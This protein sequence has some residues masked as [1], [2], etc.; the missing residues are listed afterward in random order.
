MRQRKKM[1]PRLA[2]L[3]I[4]LAICFPALSKADDL[5]PGTRFRGETQ[6]HVIEIPVK[7]ID[8]KTGRAVRDLEADDF[9]ILED[10]RRQEISN[11][12]E[13]DISDPGS[14]SPDEIRHLIYFFDLYLMK[15]GDRD[16][17]V[18]EIRKHYERG[19]RPSEIVSIASFDGEM[20]NHLDSSRDSEAI[21]RA[22]DEVEKL[23][24]RG[25]SQR[26]V[27]TQAL[28]TE[29]VSGE[30]K[31]DYYDRRHRSREFMM[32]LERRV[33]KTG[34]AI[35]TVLRRFSN[36]RGRKILIVFSP[37]QP[38]TDW[39]P[40]YAPVDYLNGEVAYP[41]RGLWSEVA[42]EAADLGYSMYVI[43]SRGLDSSTRF[44]ADSGAKLTGSAAAGRDF[45]GNRRENSEVERPNSGGADPGA[46]YTA[47]NI[48]PWI[49]KNRKSML[50]SSAEMTGGKVYFSTNIDRGVSE[51]ENSWRHW[52][53]LAYIVDHGRKGERHDIEVRIPAHP[54]YRV[55][56]RRAYIDR[57]AS[58]RDAETTRSAML[59]GSDANPLGI[60][61]EFGESRSRFRLG[62]SGAKRVRIPV[63]V[64]IPIGRL[65]LLPGGD[66]LTGRVLLTFFGTDGKGNHAPL[67]QKEQEIMIPADKLDSARNGGYFSYHITLEVEGGSQSIFVGVED[68]LSTKKSIVRSV[69]DF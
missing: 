52:Y 26:I 9:E 60:R 27:F 16:L 15:A 25:I 24:A 14:G 66:Q 10:D 47:E 13:I 55:I 43:D 63:T 2:I 42:L 36:F 4:S 30:R 17:A 5:P 39:S 7:V 44:D 34:S 37:G 3:L 41:A 8:S 58:Q 64:K 48:G 12:S 59:F 28:T 33:K 6:V 53:S 1:T 38:E 45:A 21:L 22:L 61:V 68:L 29:K 23:R 35:S 62:A 31:L 57:T 51:I 65:E 67:A 20:H 40:S 56:S 49:E 46:A 32:D 19:V 18:E 50:V 54:E 11:F 69:F